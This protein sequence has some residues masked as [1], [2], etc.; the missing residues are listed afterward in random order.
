MDFPIPNM[1][2]EV[3]QLLTALLKP[4]PMKWDALFFVKDHVPEYS[5]VRSRHR[6]LTFLRVRYFQP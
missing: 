6:R 1:P 5:G 2:T 4:S 3:Q